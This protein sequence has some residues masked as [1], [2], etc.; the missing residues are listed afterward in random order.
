[1][2]RGRTPSSDAPGTAGPREARADRTLRGAAFGAALADALD[3]ECEVTARALSLPGA[4]AVVALGSYARRELCPGSDVDVMLLHDGRASVDDVARAAEQLWYPLWDAGFVLGH[5]VRTPKE[6]LAL[7][8]SELDALTVLLDLRIVVGEKTLTGDL[9]ERAHRLARKRRGTVV[10]ALADAAALR[11]ERPGPVAEMLAPNLK[12]GAGGLRDLHA[13]DW[14]GWTLDDPGGITALAG[15][16]YLQPGD[17]DELHAARARLLDVRV[18]LHRV[19]GG[20]G[21]LLSLQDQDAVATALGATD[22]DAL[23]RDLAGA[24]RAVTWIADDVWR[25][26]VD[27][28]RGPLGRTGRR[29][30][31][32]AEGIVVRDG[33]MTLTA[34]AI[35]DAPTILRAA[36]AAAE[37]DI[38]LER[39]S[40][41]RMRDLPPAPDAT[42]WERESLDAF[43][44]LLRAG[45]RAIPVVEALDQVGVMVAL[46][47][48]WAHVRA[49]PQRNAYHR[50]TVDRHLLECVAECAAIFDEEG[51]DG[52]VAR[53]TRSDLALLGA[54]LHDIGKGLPGDHSESGAEVA[55]GVG[56]RIGLDPHG[57]DALAWLVRHHLLLA[58]TATRRDLAEESTIVR[59]G[60]AVG[61]TE[62]LDLLYVL[63]IADSRA[64]GASAWS[65][66][67]ASLVRQLFGETESLLEHGVVDARHAADQRAVI[68]RH[69]DLLAEG[70]LAFRWEDRSDGLLEC[71]VAA[72]DQRGL[73]ATMAGVLAL[74]G[75]DIRGATAYGAPGGMALEVFRGEDAFGRLDDA[76][77]RAVAQDASFALAG[78]LPLRDRLADRLKRYRPTLA[79]R[80][81]GVRVSFDLDASSVATVVEVDAPD[82]VG[83]L[84]RVAA[85]FADLDLD[86]TAALVSTLGERVVDVFYV[87]DAQGAKPTEPLALERLR[88][89]LV[90]RL[91]AQA[92]P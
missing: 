2:K 65:T 54:L 63:T 45:R 64:T 33:V 41:E 12:E 89:T 5:A 80:D 60:R 13:L 69:E 22:A 50:F 27:A 86:V 48:E 66:A 83:L 70:V 38:P 67:K 26:L 8:A 68:A 76:G 9:L 79:P 31:A 87:R 44:A 53:R 16:G 6:A 49:R 19:N 61:D 28:R 37:R 78:A 30:Q 17:A 3:A 92:L 74:H 58:D 52:D 57:V 1:M 91:A 10:E 82:E 11:R 23:V 59:F 40:L 39:H 56:E 88:A 77:R 18:A 85:V 35:L 42:R 34:D 20:R 62:R 29:D 24:A 14:A 15:A 84:A 51:F 7:A 73:L 71:A 46:V 90:A 81:A 25:R 47:P 4:F 36:A 72:P 32:V 55:R 75:F 43:L 21:D